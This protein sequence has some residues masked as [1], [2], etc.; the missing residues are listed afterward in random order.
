MAF[1]VG[2][3]KRF[4]RSPMRVLF[5]GLSVCTAIQNLV[6]K[7]LFGPHEH[8]LQVA[9]ICIEITTETRNRIS[10]GGGFPNRNFRLPVLVGVIQ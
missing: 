9:K 6:S 5:F 8:G 1:K 4:I 10:R 7:F 2:Q 3:G